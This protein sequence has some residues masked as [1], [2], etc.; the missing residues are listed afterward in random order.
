MKK[1]VKKKYTKAVSGIIVLTELYDKKG[2]IIFSKNIDGYEQSWKYNENN[3]LS[4][5][6]D[7]DGYNASYKYTEITH[8][9]LECI[10]SYGEKFIIKYDERGNEIYHH[11]T[12]IDYKIWKEY[13]AK[14]RVIMC[15]D[16]DGYTSIHEYDH[17]GNN[18][19][20]QHYSKIDEDVS[21]EVFRTY[22]SSNH[23]IE[24]K[25]SNGAHELYEY[26]FYE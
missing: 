7:S 26:E 24:L 18:V 13:D 14:N 19:Y 15:R 5:Y 23:E 21:Y 10:S 6:S 2:N 8:R 12:S 9:V 4:E 17:N 3:L 25:D 16:S 1:L 20:Q 11:D 22:D